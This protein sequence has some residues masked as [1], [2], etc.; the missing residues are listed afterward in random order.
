VHSQAVWAYIHHFSNHLAAKKPSRLF[1]YASS[2]EALQIFKTDELWASSLFFEDQASESNRALRLFL[3]LIDKLI[4]KTRVP[5]GLTR[6]LE[7]SYCTHPKRRYA[8]YQY[9]LLTG[10]KENLGAYLRGTQHLLQ[11]S[12]A[13]HEDEPSQW[14]RCSSS[15]AYA[16]GFAAEDLATQATDQHFAL[17][18]CYYASWD[19]QRTIIQGALLGSLQAWLSKIQRIY[20]KPSDTKHAY[21]KG[22]EVIDKEAK[23][24]HDICVQVAGLLRTDEL[25]HEAEW[26]LL[27]QGVPADL[28]HYDAHEQM[29]TPYA[30][31]DFQGSLRSVTIK[32]A[33]A[34]KAALGLRGYLSSKRSKEAI[35]IALSKHLVSPTILAEAA[36]EASLS[37]K[38]DPNEVDLGTHS[39]TQD[40]EYKPDIS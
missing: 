25:K 4:E 14:A 16:L 7:F 19:E 27:S 8:M 6:D 21:F 36:P 2:N 23:R 10:L 29:F 30:P 32:Q 34:A 40:F 22:L 9:L 18:P 33:Q 28:L 11:L 20:D 1:Y 38:Q 17:L 26:R 24:V 31:F 12:F 13:S 3:K 35:S 37:L 15:G 39:G 5:E